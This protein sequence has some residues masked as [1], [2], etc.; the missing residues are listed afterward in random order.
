MS[1]LHR[2]T[3]FEDLKNSEVSDQ[4]TPAD[5]AKAALRQKKWLD[6]LKTASTTMEPVRRKRKQ[7]HGK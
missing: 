4:A 2:Y 6:V 3:S 7:Q 5:A 1:N